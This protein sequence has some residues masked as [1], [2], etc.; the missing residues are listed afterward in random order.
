MSD[1]IDQ[2]STAELL[3]F[4]ILCFRNKDFE[5]A[6]ACFSAALGRDPNLWIAHLY[7]GM[8]YHQIHHLQLAME[9]FR[10][11]TTNCTDPAIRQKAESAL[12]H[13][14]IQQE[15]E[16]KLSSTSNDELNLG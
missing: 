5:K 4:S 8:S 14:T 11:L 15:K 3:E 13:L 9:H 2:L 1:G 10:F 12:N 16:R 7:I 6:I